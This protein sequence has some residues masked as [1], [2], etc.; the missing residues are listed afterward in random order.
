MAGSLDLLYIGSRDSMEQT[1]M[2]EHEV[3]FVAISCGKLRRYFSWKNLVD[4]FRIPVGIIEATLVLLKFRPEVIFCKGGYVSFPVAVAGWILGIPVVLHES[5]VSP[6]LANKLCAK[7]AKV[8]CVSFEESRKYFKQKKVVLTGNPVRHELALADAETGFTFMDFVTDLPVVLV[9][10]GSS[11]AEFVNQLVWRNLEYLLPHYQVAHVC[12]RGKV[13]SA[14]KLLEHLKPEHHKYIAHYRAFDFLDHEMKDV[15]AAADVVVS[16]AGA[17]SLAEID[18]FEKPAILI[19]LGKSASRG[20]QI[21]NADIFAKGH[22]CKILHEGEFSD[23]EF[24]DDVREMIKHRKSA[25]VGHR[26][27]DKFHALDKIIRLLEKP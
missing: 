2:E 3:P 13:Q 14:E 18:F 15:Y 25:H 8:I 9:M 5:D 4:F 26:K 27:E 16:R 1:M 7:F 17:I 12:G 21:L 10:G 20:D 22:L 19:P 24:M 11:G 23:V 6:G